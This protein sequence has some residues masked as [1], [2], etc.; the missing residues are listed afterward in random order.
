MKIVFVH[1]IEFNSGAFSEFEDVVSKTS[2]G[3]S[4]WFSI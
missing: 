2:S 1:E 4:R 3:R